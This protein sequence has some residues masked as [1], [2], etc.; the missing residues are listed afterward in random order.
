MTA[1]GATVPDGYRAARAPDAPGQL[2]MFGPAGL[3]PAIT[4]A[5]A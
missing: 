4:A 2:E 5:G 3:A 1:P